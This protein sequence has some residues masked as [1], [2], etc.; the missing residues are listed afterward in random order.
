MKVP[1]ISVGN[2]QVYPPSEALGNDTLLAFKPSV[3]EDPAMTQCHCWHCL[4]KH[5]ANNAIFLLISFSSSLTSIPSTFP[6]ALPVT[7]HLVP[8]GTLWE[9]D[10]LLLPDALTGT[11]TSCNKELRAKPTYRRACPCF[12]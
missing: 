3:Q 8:R 9:R 2:S 6:T 11:A 10:S 7:L 1:L 12:S 4:G 5:R